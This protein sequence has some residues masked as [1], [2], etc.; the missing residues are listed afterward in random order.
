MDPKQ[1]KT[2]KELG[3]LYKILGIEPTDAK[4]VIKGVYKNQARI[5]HPDKS[6]A[7]DAHD[8]YIKLKKAY[9][10]L[11]DTD[12]KSL[13]DKYRKNQQQRTE[14]ASYLN[15]QRQNFTEDLLNKERLNHQK[16]ATDDKKSKKM[17]KEEEKREEGRRMKRDW[18]Q[19]E[20]KVREELERIHR[21]ALEKVEN[22]EGGVVKVKW[23]RGQ[24]VGY[25]EAVLKIIF[26][27]YGKV[28]NVVISTDGRKALV[29]YEDKLSGEKAC[30]GNNEEGRGK[31]WSVNGFDVSLMIKDMEN[32]MKDVESEGS[33][34]LD[35]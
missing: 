29:E 21:E 10:I 18:E 30:E 7:A 14:R 1:L 11:M 31:G 8:N 4:K 19:R 23:A 25:N 3:D 27:K 33:D 22:M 16:P 2:F 9:D 35:T 26:E 24:Q 20:Q 28:R 12:L 17:S 6:K 13:F 34:K 5:L 15:R 32:D